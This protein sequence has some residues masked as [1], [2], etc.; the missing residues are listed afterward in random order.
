MPLAVAKARYTF[1]Q[2]ESGEFIIDY[3]WES[4][5]ELNGRK[6]LRAKTLDAR[7]ESFEVSKD[8]KLKISTRI[9]IAGNGDWHIADP[10]VQASGWKRVEST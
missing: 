10:R 1:S 3:V 8:A 5:A 2:R 6:P 7:N 9:T 4:S